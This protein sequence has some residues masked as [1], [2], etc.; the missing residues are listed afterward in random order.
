MQELR[1]SI[2]CADIVV[3]MIEMNTTSLISLVQIV[4]RGPPLEA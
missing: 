3:T 1:P 2:V 4:V